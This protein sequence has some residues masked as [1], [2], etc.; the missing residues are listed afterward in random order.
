M[1]KKWKIQLPFLLQKICA[2]KSCKKLKIEDLATPH[3]ENGGPV[4]T[5]T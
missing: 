4:N 1:A 2:R 5:K 3:F